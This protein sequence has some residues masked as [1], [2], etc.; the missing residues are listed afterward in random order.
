MACLF[1]S[2]IECDVHMGTENSRYTEMELE[3]IH[4]DLQRTVDTRGKAARIVATVLVA[5]DA[6]CVRGEFFA[7]PDHVMGASCFP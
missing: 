5:F 2:R 3:G 7:S 6:F 1:V 4:C